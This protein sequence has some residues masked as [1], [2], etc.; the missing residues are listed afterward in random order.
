MQMYRVIPSN[1]AVIACGR[2]HADSAYTFYRVP[3]VDT[4]IAELERAL[5]SVTLVLVQMLD[6]HQ[7]LDKPGREALNEADRALSITG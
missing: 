5:K 1:G 4:R 6:K 2:E 7:A 3:D